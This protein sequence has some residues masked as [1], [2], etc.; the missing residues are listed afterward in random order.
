[1]T[2]FPGSGPLPCGPSVYTVPSITARSGPIVESMPPP[3][4]PVLEEQ[5]HV[6]TMFVRDDRRIPAARLVRF[7]RAGGDDRKAGCHFGGDRQRRDL[8]RRPRLRLGRLVVGFAQPR[9]R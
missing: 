2:D 5:P 1:M 4:A 7:E 8:R 9:E 6:T 3:V